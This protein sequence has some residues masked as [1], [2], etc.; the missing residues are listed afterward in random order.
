MTCA[1]LSP[2][3][4]DN[5]TRVG[6]APPPLFAVAPAADACAPHCGGGRGAGDWREPRIG[7]GSTPQSPQEASKMAR[8]LHPRELSRSRA[9]VAAIAVSATLAALGAGPALATVGA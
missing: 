6:R 9:V 7:A 5:C 3:T 8:D 1:Q 2:H 4:G